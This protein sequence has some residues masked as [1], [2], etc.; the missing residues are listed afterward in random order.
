[1]TDDRDVVYTLGPTHCTSS[2]GHP[3]PVLFVLQSHRLMRLSGQPNVSVKPMRHIR[4]AILRGRDVHGNG[5]QHFGVGKIIVRCKLSHAITAI[6]LLYS[7]CIAIL[8]GHRS[9]S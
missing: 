8:L 2:T 4:P 9:S 7:N 5:N 6:G 3:K 1:M